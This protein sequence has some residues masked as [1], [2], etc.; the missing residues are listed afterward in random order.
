MLYNWNLIEYYF[1]SL[2]VLVFPQDLQ[3]VA[4]IYQEIKCI[5]FVLTQSFLTAVITK[6]KQTNKDPVWTDGLLFDHEFT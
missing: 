6:R 5:T 2:T 4:V 1:V 3:F